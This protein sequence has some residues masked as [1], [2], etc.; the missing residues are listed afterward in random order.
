MLYIT[1]QQLSLLGGAF[2]IGAALCLLEDGEWLFGSLKLR[3]AASL[4]LA[5]AKPLIEKGEGGG[6]L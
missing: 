3:A 2:A 6:L 5:F 1:V 4:F